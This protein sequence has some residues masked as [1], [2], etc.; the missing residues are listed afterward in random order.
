MTWTVEAIR[1]QNEKAKKGWSKIPIKEEPDIGPESD[2][3]I[4]AQNWMDARG[5]PW[6]HDRSRGKN[7]PGQFLDHYCFLPKARIVVFEYKVGKN[8]MTKEQKETYLKL[9]QLGH[10]VYEC[11]TFKRFLQI[12]EKPL[13]APKRGKG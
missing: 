11:R 8:K 4:K 6:L 9:M 7:K 12:V 10:E 2:L 13:T 3:Q 1:A 5:Y